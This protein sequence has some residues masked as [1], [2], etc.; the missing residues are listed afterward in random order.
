LIAA[1]NYSFLILNYMK[2]FDVYPLFDVNIVKGKGCHVWDDKGQEYLDLYGGHAV[3][4]IGHAHP[5][6]VETISKQV[7][8][9][10][11]Y[12]NSVINKLQQE[13]ADRLG[14]ISGYDDYQLFL[15]NSG[16]EAN[17]NALKLA[18]F[19]NGRTRVISFA[20][21]FHGRTS[22]AVEV[23]NNPKIIAPINDNGHVTYLQLN[24]TEAL[25]AEL[26]KGDVCA[27]IIEGIQ[28][29]GG[30]QLPTTEFMK[31]IRQACDETNTVMILDEIQSGYGRSGKFFAHQYN[32]VR[33]DMITVAKGIGNGFPMAGVLISPKFTP[34]YGQLGTT[35]GGNHL[36]CAAAI[37]VLD[38]MKEEN[39]V[40]NAAKVGAH[41]LEELKG[42]KG[43]KEVRG[44]GLMIGM[45]FEEPIKELRQKL[46]FEEKVFT[47]VSGANVIR[48]LP[49]LCLSMNE[50]D[51]FL[52]RLHHVTK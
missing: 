32:D 26:A 11:F 50:A 25:K 37:A 41:L 34:V 19:Y 40:E 35:F 44:R 4:S 3:I 46:L 31:A 33:P 36:A 30:I 28:G 49:P 10:G 21:A 20:K 17:E 1:I 39:L 23:T 24:D 51:E 52:N 16:A 15:I 2:L 7:A 8:T 47:G 18:S 38:V 5:H 22:L 13:V 48:L 43:I 6:Y 29:V 14:A 9:L 27:V 45:E 42:F 12:S